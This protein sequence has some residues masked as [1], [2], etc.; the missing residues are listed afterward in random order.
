MSDP[1]VTSFV[2][3]PAT[4]KSIGKRSLILGVGVNDAPYVISPSIN[5]KRSTCKFYSTWHSMLQRCYD[6]RVLKSRP[7]YI[8]C[9]V[10]SEWHKFMKFRSWMEKQDWQGNALDKDIVIDGNKIYSPETCVFVSQGLNNL[11]TGCRE[12]DGKLPPGVSFSRRN[13]KYKVQCGDGKGGDVFLGYHDSPAEAYTA[14]RRFKKTIILD[15][16]HQQTNN[17][18]KCALIARSKN[19]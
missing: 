7:C 15:I 19:L 13:N 2:E 12:V 4:K 14:W 1:I 6:T 9:S 3:I 8:G 5:G 16:A 17:I 18:V 10:I 11:L